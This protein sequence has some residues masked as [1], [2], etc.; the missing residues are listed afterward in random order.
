MRALIFASLFLF[1]CLA[2][3][4]A[5]D[6]LKA[7]NAARSQIGV[8][9]AYDPA[10][11]QLAYPMGDV[12][13]VRGVCSDVIIRAYRKAGV[14]F[15]MLV[16]R[17][18]QNNFS[19]YPKL[20]GLKKTDSNIDHRRVP[21]LEVFFKRQGKSVADM[22][23]AEGFNPGDIVSWRLSNG[24][25]HIGMVSNK[26]SIFGSRPLIIHNIG[27]GTREEDVLFAWQIVGHYRWFNASGVSH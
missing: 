18:M 12:P 8:T 25:A 27:Q 9:T 24:L 21:N 19:V 15:Q 2:S 1:S 14:D 6:A 17:D 13:Q 7:V 5:A 16:H 20:W 4:Q 10:Y 11:S 22:Q 23:T 3:A 26:R